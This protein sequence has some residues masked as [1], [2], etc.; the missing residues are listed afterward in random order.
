M[1]T[2]LL[3]NNGANQRLITRLGPQA[4]VV[5]LRWDDRSG[6]W[7]LGL[8]AGGLTIAQG[9]RVI[10]G[11]RLLPRRPEDWQLVALP[12]PDEAEGEDNGND[13]AEVGR[14]GWGVTHGLYYIPTSDGVEW[15]R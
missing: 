15:L 8:T 1:P 2:Q 4:V 9:R 14:N 5:D 6:F 3:I 7:Y 11:V 12:L 13:N 10:V